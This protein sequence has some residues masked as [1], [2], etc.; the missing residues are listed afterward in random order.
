MKDFRRWG[1]LADWE[2]EQYYT[3]FSTQYESEQIKVFQYLFEK[4]MIF[5]A[6]KPVYWSPSSKSALAE[7]ELEYVD[8]HQSLSV[9]IKYKFTEES[10][11]KLQQHFPSI[12]NVDSVIIWTT[13]PWTLPGSLAVAHSTDL[14]YSIVQFQNQAHLILN[15]QA[16]SIFEDEV[17][18]LGKISGQTL[19]EMKLTTK[20]PFLDRIVPLI[21]SEF[22][23]EGSGSGFVHTAPAHGQED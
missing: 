16:P 1:V 23:I 9:Y 10:I 5:R 6:L 15:S 2:E 7:S 22:V 14:T 13:T 18:E 4:E 12:P 3:T 19:S 11:L 17:E 21:E 20:H 8:N